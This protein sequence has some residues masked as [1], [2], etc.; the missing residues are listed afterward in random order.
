MKFNYPLETK[1]I[2]VLYALGFLLIFG[3]AFAR[4]CIDSI[5]LEHYSNDDLPK[6]WLIMA[7]F[8]VFVI[9]VYNQLNQKYAI[10]K[11]YAL[12]SNLSA[13]TLCLLLGLYFSGFTPAIFILYIWKEIYMVVLVETYW[14]YAD[15]VFS[16]ETAK[17]NYGR[18]LA[19][20]SVGGILGN[21]VVWPLA[22]TLGAR[23]TLCFLVVFLILGTLIAQ[24]VKGVSDEKPKVK[25]TDFTLGVSTLLKSKYLIPLGFLICLVQIVIGLIDYQFNGMLKEHYVNTDLRTALLG[26]IHA[27]VNIF[28]ISLQIL[29]GPILKVLGIGPTFYSIPLTLGSFIILFIL[30]PKFALM[31]AVKIT[32]KTL[33]YSLMRGVKEILYIPLSREEKTQ[34]KGIIDIFFYRLA[35][36][37]SALILI[38]MINFGIKSYFMQIA[39]VFVAVWLILALIIAKRYKALVQSNDLPNH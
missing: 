28:G 8:S 30:L 37:F 14:S 35:R 38:A 19:V 7:V 5:F 10:L 23:I 15:I 1:R 25:K 2:G 18:A 11:L 29:T 31:L 36:G 12:A 21:L 33:D 6:A 26:Q 3:Y 24:F 17:K 20:S 34:G 9:S 13:L 4:P 27:A 16:T 32:S 22:H 39:L